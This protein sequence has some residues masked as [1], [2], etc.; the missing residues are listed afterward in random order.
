[1]NNKTINRFAQNPINLDIQRSTFNRSSDYSTTFKAGDLVPF[2]VEEVLPGDTFKHE[3]SAIVRLLTPVA[4]TMSNAYLDTFYFYVPH[5]LCSNDKTW[6][7]INGENTDGYWANKTETVDK[8]LYDYDD[9]MSNIQPMS[10]MNYMGLPITDDNEIEIAIS[11]KVISAPFT[12]YSMIW[13]D[14]FRDQNTQPPLELYDLSG[15]IM[16]RYSQ[17]SNTLKVNKFHDY[18]TSCLPAPQ[19]GDSVKL[20]LGISAPVGGLLD[21]QADTTSHPF[22]GVLSLNT[23]N[24]IGGNKSR[25]LNIANLSGKASKDNLPIIGYSETGNPTDTSQRIT[26]SNLKIRQALTADLSNAT[27]ATVN[28]LR[29]AFALQ[30]VLEKDARGGTRYK[31]ILKA[32]F[33]ITYPDMTLQR[34]EYLGGKRQL[35]NINQVVQT[36]AGQETTTNLG[37]T[38]AVSNTGFNNKDFVKSFGE[39]GYIIGVMC[40]RTEQTYCQG[41]PKLFTKRR[42]YD[43][44]LPTFANLGE[45]P[46]NRYELDATHTDINATGDFNETDVFGYQEYGADYRYKPS[47]ITGNLAPTSGDKTLNAWTYAETYEKKPIL[48]SDFMYQTASA[49][50]KTL[51]QTDTATQF[52]INMHFNTLATRPLPVYS[53]PGLIDHH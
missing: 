45:Q 9:D 39:H 47:L 32:H 46:I 25:A 21:L 10:V 37:Y 14:F 29:Q 16:N 28:S 2:F 50:G 41:I 4:P 19:K 3:T 6:E 38:G 36:S 17:A 48:N 24:V 51:Y 49:I 42:R 15:A 27:S 7:K 34:P 40:V 18:F 44:Y 23:A 26:G 1:M 53:V 35:L 33:N 30:R 20:S 31:E 5:R 22:N 12:A 11:K 52:L 8:V 43:Y 13:N